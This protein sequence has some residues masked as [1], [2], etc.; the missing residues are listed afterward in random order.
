MIHYNNVLKSNNKNMV[1]R[2]PPMNTTLLESQT[3]RAK[4]GLTV[5]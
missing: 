3:D 1:F 2:Q 4:F 5:L